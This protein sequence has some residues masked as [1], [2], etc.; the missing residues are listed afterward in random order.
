M[1]ISI[2]QQVDYL[3]KKVGFGLTK[4]ATSDVKNASNESIVSSPFI[5]GDKIWTQSSSIPS[6]IPASSE[7]V[8][9]V[10]SDSNA[11]TVRCTMDITAAVNRTWL[12]NLIDWVPPV[13]GATYQP[14]VYLAD[15]LSTSPMTEGVQLYANGSDNDDEWFFDFQSGVLHFIGTN[16]PNQDFTGKSIFI[17]GA[18]YVGIKGV[19]SS[20][21]ASFGNIT[22]DGST[23]S[24]TNSIILA[25][26]S[27][28]VYADGVSIIGLAYPTTAN[29]AA[30]VE[31]VTNVLGNVS[32]NSISQGDT[33]VSVNDTGT[34]N[35]AVIVDNIQVAEYTSSGATIGSIGISGSTIT[36]TTDIVTVGTT[37]ALQISVGTTAERPATPAAGF[38]RYNTTTN[39]IEY[40][41]GENWISSNSVIASQI[42][43]G[44]G[45][46]ITYTLD[47][48]SIATGIMVMINGVVQIPDVAYQVSGTDITFAEAPLTTDII[49]IRYISQT[50][51][52][53]SSVPNPVIFAEAGIPV[54]TTPIVIDMFSSAA[55]RT[56]RYSISA[57]TNDGNYQTFDISVIHNGTTA[58][59]Q[60]GTLLSTGG[61]T[62]ISFTA[63]ITSNMCIVSAYT[64][65]STASL[66]VQK[67]YFS[68]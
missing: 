12:T 22:I 35:V 57:D 66:K 9:L 43:V 14:K 33:I 42:I 45:I 55:Y 61:T 7:G 32:T 44:D 51:A 6:I 11:N 41:D 39:L 47:T 25:P 27:S 34:G 64:S 59:I 52:S 67:T 53:P 26:A 50:I 5:P 31:Y 23:I 1:T 8:V 58:F 49:E 10:Y 54:S 17:S 4:T 18:R 13:V 30:T 63:T 56:A 29:S 46:T 62:V 24:S 2:N 65:T 38:I 28:N 68:V 37:G 21:G 40:Y 15:S 3:W 48:S 36:S 20:G 60:A 16:L 19:A